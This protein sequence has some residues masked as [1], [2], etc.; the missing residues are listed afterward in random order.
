LSPEAVNGDHN[1]LLHRKRARQRWFENVKEILVVD[2]EPNIRFLV[3]VTLE[4]AGYEVVEAHHGVAA[5]ERAKESRPDLVVTDLMMPVMGGRALIER[6]RSNPETAAIPI[7]VISAN[8]NLDV[9]EADAA[10]SKPFDPD[11]L[12]ENVCTLSQEAGSR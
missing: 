7:L 5:L 11:E 6:L 1:R 8:G 9:G 4:A 2:D 12:L 10:L 3:R